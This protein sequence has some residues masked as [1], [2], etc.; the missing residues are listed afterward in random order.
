MG[1]RNFD[2]RAKIFTFNDYLIKLS[3]SRDKID[4]P[5]NGCYFKSIKDCVLI[6]RKRR[7]G[8]W[9]RI[10][11]GLRKKVKD[12]FMD[13]KFSRTQRES[14]IIIE[15][16]VRLKDFKRIVAVF[17]P[18]YGFRVSEDF[19]IDGETGSFYKMEFFPQLSENGFE[20]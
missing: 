1:R 18:D 16:L 13:Q 5:M 4:K 17:I 9:I 12:L 10:H 19:Y 6:F 15:T 11:N 14:S 8:D 2:L 7:N 3:L 20:D